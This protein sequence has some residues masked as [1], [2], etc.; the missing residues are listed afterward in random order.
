VVVTTRRELGTA[1][2]A[3][4]G[5]A[6]LRLGVL[7]RAASV[8]LLH[9]LT[10]LDDAVGAGRLAAALGDLP[11]ALEQAA[12][13]VSQHNGFGFGDYHRLL[14]DRFGLVA[15]DPGEGGSV[16]RTVATI[17]RASMD[18]VAARPLLT[19]RVLGALAWL[20]PD[21]LPEDVLSGLA[22]DPVAVGAAPAVLAS[23]SLVTRGAGQVSVHRLVQAVV[24]QEQDPATAADAVTAA[25]AAIKRAIP[26]D[27]MTNVAGWPRWNQLL[28]H[29]DA[30]TGHAGPGHTYTDLMYVNDQAATY[31]QVQ[32]QPAAAIGLFEQVLTDR[33]RVLGDDH[34][35]TLNSRNNLAG[36]YQAAGRVAEAIDLYEQLLTDRRRVLGDDHPDTRNTASLLRN[37]LNENDEAKGAEPKLC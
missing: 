4:L 6:P 29:I 8:Q 30:L 31:R 33:R 24:R 26:D 34:P 18:A 25:V 35:R 22:D 27:P 12:A 7:D 15:A 20:A 5:L 37:A 17:W 10:G 36:A 9:R 32:G 28:P 2:W 19:V 23:F 21:A 14:T 13:Y 11:L 16:Q 1:R 3:R